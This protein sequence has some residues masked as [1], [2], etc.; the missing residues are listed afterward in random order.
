MSN[1]RF[2]SSKNESSSKFAPA[3]AIGA[4]VSLL[5]GAIG[6]IGA[7]KQKREAERKEAA[8]R[9]EMKRQE[10]IYRGIDLSNPFEN[11]TNRFEGLQNQ[12]AG[13]ENVAE[14]LTKSSKYTRWTKRCSWW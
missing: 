1:I 10:E 8:A 6:A 7:G 2:E 14:D 13:M 12:Y 3:L 11:L 9:E 5:T 4:G